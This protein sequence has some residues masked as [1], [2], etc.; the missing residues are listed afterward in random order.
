[1][2]NYATLLFFCAATRVLALETS[3]V[4]FNASAEPTTVSIA[5]DA[6]GNLVF[7]DVYTSATTLFQLA[8]QPVLHG[9][10]AGLDAD[11]HPHYLNVGRHDAVHDAGYNDALALSGD[12]GGNTTL[13]AHVSDGDIH[14][15]RNGEETITGEWTFGEA[16]FDGGALVL[17]N[18]TTSTRPA[19]TFA[20]A[21]AG[22][23]S[24]DATAPRFL[25]DRP[26]RASRLETAGQ[27]DGLGTATL[28]N[29]ATIA[30]IASEDLVASTASESISA[31]WTFLAGVSTETLTQ[32]GLPTI[33]WRVVNG[34][35]NSIAAGD[36][37]AWSGISGGLPSVEKITGEVSAGTPFAGIAAT[38][39]TSTAE[40]DIVVFGIV[41]ATSTGSVSAGQA[42]AWDGDSIGPIGAT[43]GYGQIGIALESLTGTGSV[44]V[45]VQRFQHPE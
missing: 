11:H 17:G 20:A 9:A 21:M 30:G 27:V 19:I 43:Y 3:A 5:R 29:F 18:S 28:E 1:M 13:G 34:G 25:F 10:L 24:Y 37:V 23:F 8:Q 38:G 7:R 14:L 16:R 26:V 33:R 15:A 40:L 35:L 42:I 22:E 44:A 39:G 12:V 2:K 31:P 45:F 36:A 4:E 32:N 41:E 6:S